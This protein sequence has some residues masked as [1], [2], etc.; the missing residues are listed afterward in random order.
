MLCVKEVIH[1]G[2]PTGVNDSVGVVKLPVSFVSS[3]G[4]HKRRGDVPATSLGGALFGSLLGKGHVPS[5]ST[6]FP[7][8][9]E[10]PGRLKSD[11][12]SECHDVSP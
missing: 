10:R 6:L 8:S 12:R 9:G 1:H 11:S 4:V 3:H 2:A 7:A 5:P